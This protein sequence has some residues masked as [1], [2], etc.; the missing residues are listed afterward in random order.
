MDQPSDAALS[1]DVSQREEPKNAVFLSMDDY[2]R[3]WR[4]SIELA[5]RLSAEK[6]REIETSFQLAR[7]RADAIR[8]GRVEPLSAWIPSP[9]KDLVD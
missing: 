1:D 5:T 4:I 2:V 8:E 9:T 7:K 3:N 6:R